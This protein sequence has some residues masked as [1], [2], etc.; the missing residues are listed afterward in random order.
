[1]RLTALAKSLPCNWPKRAIIFSLFPATKSCLPKPPKKSVRFYRAR[2]VLAANPPVSRLIADKYQVSAQY[3]SIDFAKADESA[4]DAFG[5][6]IKGRDVGV[7]G[8]LPESF[9]GEGTMLLN[10]FSSK[11]RREVT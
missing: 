7:L 11:Q 10:Q 9:A 6:V 1:M 8:K 4:Y 2:R 3:H 5:A